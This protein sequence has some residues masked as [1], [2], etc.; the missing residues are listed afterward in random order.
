VGELDDCFEQFFVDQYPRLVAIGL[1]WTN[2]RDT[3]TDVAQ[4]TLT[5]A[6]SEWGRV[7]RLES[8]GGWATRVMTN[9][10]IDGHRRRQ[11]EELVAANANLPAGAP[12]AITDDDWR[13]AVRSLPPRQR[14]AIVL[15]Y[16]A[17]L[18]VDEVADIMQ[19]APGTVKATLSQA[20]AALKAIVSN[21]VTT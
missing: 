2:D 8:P 1:A 14:A 3:A 12:V 17:D 20:R 6:L 9:L 13:T 15:Y 7:G 10:L 5:R 18:S 11:R 19:A 16:V 4:E 21:E